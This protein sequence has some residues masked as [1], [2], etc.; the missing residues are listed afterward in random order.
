MGIPGFSDALRL[1]CGHM[2]VGPPDRLLAAYT[3][4]MHGF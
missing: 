3:P 4:G 1:E 2:G